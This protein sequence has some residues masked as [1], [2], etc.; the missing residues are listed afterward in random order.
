MSSFTSRR[1][2]CFNS[3]AAYWWSDP[4]AVLIHGVAC[5]L[6]GILGICDESD[7]VVTSVRKRPGP[8][9]F[10]DKMAQ[11]G[12][13]H[14]YQSAAGNACPVTNAAGGQGSDP[15]DLQ[16]CNAFTSIYRKHEA[17]IGRHVAQF[18]D[19]QA[20]IAEKREKNEKINSLEAQLES[21]ASLEAQIIER[22][23]ELET[24]IKTIQLNGSQTP[25][26]DQNGGQ[27]GI[28]DGAEDQEGSNEVERLQNLVPEEMKNEIDLEDIKS[29]LTSELTLTVKKGNV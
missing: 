2:T 13:S 9:S 16:I 21:K 24:Q 1:Q 25:S 4:I 18:E 12:K 26:I 20:E 17:A 19:I 8:D 7:T 28:Q 6:L 5:F 15:E 22:I 29:R 11:V 10:L 14:S 23:H 3:S 27:R